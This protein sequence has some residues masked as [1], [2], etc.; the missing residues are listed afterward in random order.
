MSSN[1]SSFKELNPTLSLWTVALC[2]ALVLSAPLDG[3]LQVVGPA[4]PITAV[5][6]DD[7]IL[8]CCLEPAADVQDKTI[9]WSDP[10]LKLDPLNPQRGV[11]YVHLYRNRKEVPDMQ[12]TSYFGRT[13]LFE[14]ELKRGNISLKITNVTM[15]DQGRYR[16]FIP[17]LKS[18]ANAAI[19]QL[20]VVPNVVETSTKPPLDLRNLQTPDPLDDTRPD[21]GRTLQL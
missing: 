19:V 6:G 10:D 17:K 2:S 8:P 20:V 15:E 5:L 4:Q 16:C 7:I 13:T 9:L 14:D 12:I 11:E 1:K 21:G 18:R 3:Q